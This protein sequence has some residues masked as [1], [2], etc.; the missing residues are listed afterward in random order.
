MYHSLAKESA[1]LHELEEVVAVA[2][3]VDV[4]ARALL[5][6]LQ[7]QLRLVIVVFRVLLKFSTSIKIETSCM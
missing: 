6:P 4:L 5:D 7:Q 1:V 2:G 3:G